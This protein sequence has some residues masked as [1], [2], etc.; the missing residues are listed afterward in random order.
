MQRRGAS[1]RQGWGRM[2]TADLVQVQVAD[3][4]AEEVGAEGDVDAGATHQQEKGMVEDGEP[5]GDE[6]ET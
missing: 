1:Q 5:G 3:A 2:E 6:L 4:D